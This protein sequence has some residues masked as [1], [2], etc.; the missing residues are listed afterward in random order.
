MDIPGYNSGYSGYS[1]LSGFGLDHQGELFFCLLQTGGNA[2]NTSSGR[3]FKLVQTGSAGDPPIPGT[4]AQTGAFVTDPDGTLT[5]LTP[6]A[7]L[8]PYTVN[9]PLWSDGAEKRRWLAVPQPGGGS[10]P[11]TDQVAYAAT[12]AWNFP[13]GTVFVKHFELTVDERSASLTKRRLETRLLVRQPAPASGVYGVTYRWRPDGRNADVLTSDVSETYDVIQAN[14]TVR[15]Q[16]WYYPSRADCLTCHNANAGHVLGV[17]TRQLNGSCNYPSGVSDNQLRTWNHLGLLDPALAEAAI[18]TLSR[19][20]ALD[21]AGATLEKRCRSWLDANCSHCHRPGGVQAQFD[22]RFDTTLRQQQLVDVPTQLTYPG[23][24]SPRIIA[25]GDLARSLL[26]QRDSSLQVGFMMPP[27]AKSRVDD[28][29]MTRMQA[30]IGSLPYNAGLTL[31][32]LSQ[33]YNGSPRPVTVAAVT[34]GVPAIAVTYDGN[35]GAPI[36]AGSY[37]VVATVAPDP[38]YSGST[39]GTLVIAKKTAAIVL[40][41]LTATYDGSS[42]AVSPTTTP[43]GLTVTLTYDGIGT[44]PTAAGSYAVQATVVDANHA[45]SAAGTLT[46]AP[47]AATVALS[48]LTQ[49]A[50]GTPRVVTAVTSP[51][52]LAVAITY[53]GVASAPSAPGSYAVVATITDPNRTGSA[54]GTLVVQAPAGGGPATP[55]S[56]GGGGGGGGCGLGG[57]TAALVAL[58]AL[59]A[60]RVIRLR[61][62]G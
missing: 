19:M 34:D 20:A 13:A 51:V 9:T 33:V 17:N 36:Q 30:W 24:A 46:I 38:L 6:V 15:R 31:S 29:A 52:G 61:P 47:A 58:L 62:R 26:F 45:G 12:G 37:A 23:I 57:G 49:T 22:A 3:I 35:P 32:G 21:D 10:N 16:T 7:G 59:L 27:L 5:S 40:N 42:H 39:S 14:G 8:I 44:A 4:L 50:D 43:S 41:G 18:P 28:Q 53:A 25:H 55:S 11:L 1:G 2:T 56:D 54:S 48:G 60:L